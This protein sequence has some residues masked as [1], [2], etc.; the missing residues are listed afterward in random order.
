MAGS[1]VR[2]VTDA[3]RVEAWWRRSQPGAQMAL[4]TGDIGE[5]GEAVHTLPA[6]FGRAHLEGVGG[7]IGGV[8]IAIAEAR[9]LSD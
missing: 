1:P 2:E 5:V 4:A 8:K 9:Q 3:A 7:L 6:A